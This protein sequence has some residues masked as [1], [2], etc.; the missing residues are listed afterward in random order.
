M[1]E[2]IKLKMN[3]GLTNFLCSVTPE[4][5]AS[6][7][8]Q[9]HNNSYPFIFQ[10]EILLEL[11]KA[12]HEQQQRF[13]VVV[14]VISDLQLSQLTRSI[15]QFKT[16]LSGLT[17]R[18]RSILDFVRKGLT[19]KQIANELCISN[20]TVKSHRKNILLRTGY[21]GFDEIK[22]TMQQADNYDFLFS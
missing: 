4:M 20:E 8:D 9:L 18:E 13:T 16:T 17:K 2:A 21:K 7:V 10:Q 1:I 11:M 3:D 12:L 15:R 5:D 6:L 22:E 19:T 14:D